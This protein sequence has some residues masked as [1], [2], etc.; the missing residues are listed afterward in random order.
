MGLNK[1]LSGKLNFDLSQASISHI[2]HEGQA[3]RKQG[4]AHQLQNKR[5]AKNKL[6]TVKHIIYMMSHKASDTT[7]AGLMNIR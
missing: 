5:G 1:T 6:L 7:G 3:D 4:V 2:L